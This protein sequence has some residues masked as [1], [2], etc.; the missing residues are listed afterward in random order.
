M[1]AGCGTPIRGPWAGLATCEPPPGGAARAD[2]ARADAARAD[3][4]CTGRALRWP[5]QGA[6]RADAARAD[7]ACTEASIQAR[8]VSMTSAAQLP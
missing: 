1:G 2:A 7:A 4:A 8:E 3:A 6:A 5:S